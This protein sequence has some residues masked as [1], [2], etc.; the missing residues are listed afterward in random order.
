LS[1]P[2]TE[3]WQDPCCGIPKGPPEVGIIEDVPECEVSP[4][5]GVSTSLGDLK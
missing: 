2:L 3:Q 1:G 4:I 5:E